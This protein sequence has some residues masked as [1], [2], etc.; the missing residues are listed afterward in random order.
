MRSSSSCIVVVVQPRARFLS[1]TLFGY[2]P[3]KA[4]NQQKTI[5]ARYS[6]CEVY[7][8]STEFFGS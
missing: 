5:E 2:P 6:V 3:K 4:R 7:R 8:L 1:W